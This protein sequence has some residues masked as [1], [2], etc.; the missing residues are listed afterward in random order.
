ML[1]CYPFRHVVYAST[2]V[3]LLG[4]YASFLS[5]WLHDH[6]SS[7]KTWKV[8]S[9]VPSISCYTV[10]KTNARY[11]RLKPVG[12]RPCMI[13]SLDRYRSNGISVRPF[14]RNCRGFVDN[15]CTQSCTHNLVHSVNALDASA[16]VSTC[17]QW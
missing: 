3:T 12:P 5:L 8:S 17:E 7:P 13:V 2:E 16:T 15:T 10:D 1:P 9:S 11:A 4:L 14:A 6:A